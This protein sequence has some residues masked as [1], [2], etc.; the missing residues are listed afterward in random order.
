V[1]AIISNEYERLGPQKVSTFFPGD[2]THTN[3][4]GAEVNA[5]CVVAGLKSLLDGLVTRF[6][7]DRG[8]EVMSGIERSFLSPANP[9]LPTLWIIGDSTVRNGDGKG[10]HGLWGWGDEIAPYFNFHKVNVVNRAVG[11]LSSRTYYNFYWPQLLLLLKPGD[12]VLMQFGHNDGGP[13]DDAFRARGSL[14]GTGEETRTIQ[15]PQTGKPEVVHTFGWYLKQFITETR[16]KR[17]TPILCPLVPRNHWKDGKVNREH[18]AEWA[19]EIAS[20]KKLPSST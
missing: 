9:R 16:A 15:N 11:G 5:N 7:S 13:L 20:L 19:T 1:N 3:P 10:D 2:H 6:L 12:Y 14:P 17:A 8:R 4:E 18:Y